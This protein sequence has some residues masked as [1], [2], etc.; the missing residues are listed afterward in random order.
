MSSY[1]GSEHYGYEGEEISL[2]MPTNEM[3]A[4]DELNHTGG[5]PSKKNLNSK[6]TVADIWKKKFQPVGRKME[7]RDLSFMLFQPAKGRKE[8]IS[9]WGI[10]GL[11]KSAL[12]KIVYYED[13]QNYDHF[14]KHGWVNVSRPF[15][16][17][18]FSGSLLSDLDPEALQ[19]KG[20]S[21]FG[22]MGIKDPIQECCKLLHE[23]KFLVVID[24]L[25][26]TDEWDL[27][28]A[29]L[30]NG[31]CTSCVIVVT[32]EASVATHCAVPD[33]A[34]FNVKGLETDEALELFKK[35]Y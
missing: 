12:V 29:A 3:S 19:A 10:A 14:N 16:L 11:G 25:Q 22:M 24:G 28:K 13:I 5:L 8:V 35:E 1:E 33:D 27:I 32:D 23:D 18:D 15:N 17:R 31:S 26:S 9:V 30:P 7:K 34:V 6:R 20:T 4:E 21:D 2:V